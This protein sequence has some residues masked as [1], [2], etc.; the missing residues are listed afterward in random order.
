LSLG[1]TGRYSSWL[2]LQVSRSNSKCL[3]DDQERTRI[4]AEETGKMRRQMAQRDETVRRGYVSLSHDHHHDVASRLEIR[5]PFT[6]HR[7]RRRRQLPPTVLSDA[8]TT[9]RLSQDLQACG[10]LIH[11][12]YPQQFRDSCTFQRLFR[13]DRSVPIF[14]TVDLERWRAHIPL[15]H[16][17]M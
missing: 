16:R 12:L 5:P 2:S 7:S 11:C 3:G 1:A 14:R 13:P 6:A 17:H 4:R 10:F 9:A 15:Q 8:S